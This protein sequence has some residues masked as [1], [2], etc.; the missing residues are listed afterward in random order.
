MLEF[1][2]KNLK[3]ILITQIISSILLIIFSILV[4]FFF[5]YK[6]YLF[7][8]LNLPIII[9]NIIV[10]SYFIYLTIFKRETWKLILIIFPIFFILIS[11][12]SSILVFLNIKQIYSIGL[13]MSFIIN[14]LNLFYIGLSFNKNHNEFGELNETNK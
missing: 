7:G 12:A 2:N 5:K 13:L 10:Y 8:F 1:I 9:F 3:K 4:I 14:L 11:L 6:N